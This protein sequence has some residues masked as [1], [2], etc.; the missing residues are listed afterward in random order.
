MSA[1]EA[2]TIVQDLVT[3]RAPAVQDFD[4]FLKVLK[5]SLKVSD[6]LLLLAYDRGGIGASY[7]QLESWV[8]PSMRTNLRRSLHRLVHESAYLHFDGKKY[9]IT[10]SGI[11]EVESKHL[12]DFE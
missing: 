1:D 2:Q 10:L 7:E 12:H 9:V 8:K 3:R 11:T 4:G 5:P 6:H